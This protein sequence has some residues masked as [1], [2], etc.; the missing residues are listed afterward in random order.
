[1]PGIIV[2]VGAIAVNNTEKCLL[3]WILYSIGVERQR[4]SKYIACKVVIN[5]K[6][7]K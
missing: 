5:M 4:T 2:G 3:S 6:K 7:E 1:M